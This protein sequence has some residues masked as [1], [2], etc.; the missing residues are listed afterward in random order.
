MLIVV[1]ACFLFVGTTA[2]IRFQN[3]EHESMP[4][5]GDDP[6]DDYDEAFNKVSSFLGSMPL[7]S[8]PSPTWASTSPESPSPTW[9]SIRSQSP[10]PTWASISSPPV[11]SLGD[12][13]RQ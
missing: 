10:S 7:H 1:C 5:V 2:A 12:W 4:E 9:I 8:R 11:V 6:D 13:T 3:Q